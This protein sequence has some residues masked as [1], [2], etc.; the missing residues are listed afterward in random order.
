M[1]CAIYKSINIYFQTIKLLSSLYE[2]VLDM[3]LLVGLL[4]EEKHESLVGP[5]GSFLMEEQFYRAKFGNRF[6]YSLTDNP[7]PF[8]KGK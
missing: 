3:D 6:F 2:S 1:G 8:T 7:N 4:L 5:V